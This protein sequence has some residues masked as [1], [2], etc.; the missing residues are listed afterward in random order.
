MTAASVEGNVA[1]PRRR[2]AWRLPSWLLNTLILLGLWQLAS[3]LAGHTVAGAH[4]VPSL[5]DIGLATKLLRNYWP[6]GPSPVS[7]P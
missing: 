1:A 4:M 2:A 5:L 6:G 3:L 7:A